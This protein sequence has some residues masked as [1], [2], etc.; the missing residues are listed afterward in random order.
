MPTD[1]KRLS[2]TLDDP[3]A[4]LLTWLSG[5]TGLSESGIINRLLGA[6]VEELWE[7]RTWLEKQAQ[8]TAKHGMGLNLLVS[9]GQEGLVQGIKRLDPGYQTI[10][11][12]FAASV[13]NGT[14]RGEQ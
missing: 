9:Y 10:G 1:K 7:F 2:V 14:T 4:E 12:A 8:G 11:E 6:H 5:Q 13:G 3:T